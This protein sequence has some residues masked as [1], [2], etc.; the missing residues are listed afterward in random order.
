M[1]DRGQDKGRL[2]YL[3]MYE[4]VY[5]LNESGRGGGRWDVFLRTL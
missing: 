2:A 1:R 4:Y 5:Q 3:A